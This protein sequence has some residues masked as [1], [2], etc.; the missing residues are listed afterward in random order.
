MARIGAPGTG[1]SSRDPSKAVETPAGL[2]SRRRSSG[3]SRKST[4]QQTVKINGNTVFINGQGFTVA[5]SLQ[6]SFIQGRTG[7]SGS[8]AQTAIAQAQKAQAAIIAK[9]TAAK[10]RKIAEAKIAAAKTFAEKQKIARQYVERKKYDTQ[11]KKILSLK[12]NLIK[13][14]V[15]ENKVSSTDVKT[16]DKL[17]ITQWRDRRG[18]RVQEKVNKST[19]ETT[20]TSFQRP[21]DGGRVRQTGG[22]TIGATPKTATDIA[23]TYQIIP[24]ANPEW[25]FVRMPNGS[26]IRVSTTKKSIV[27]AGVAGHKLLFDKGVIIAVDGKTTFARDE[28]V[29]PEPSV[30]KFER[31]R[32][33]TTTETIRIDS[34]LRSIDNTRNKLRTQKERGKIKKIDDIKLFGYG[35]LSALISIGGGLIGLPETA[36]RIMKDPSMLKQIPSAI[37]KSGKEFGVMLRTSPTEAFGVIAG[38]VVGMVGTTAAINQVSKLSSSV[39]TKLNPR[40][41]GKAVLGKNLNIKTGGGKS[42]NLEV[43]GKI[44]KEKLLSQVNKQGQKL[45]AISSQADDLINFFNKQRTIRKPIPGEATFNSAT[46]TLLKK[47]DS[48]T[49]TKMELFD[50]DLLVRSQGAKGLLE[51]AFFADPT[52]K[53]RPSRLGVVDSNKAG[54]MDYLSGDITFR[55]ARPQILLFEDIKVA[56][57]P[58]YLK[59]VASKIKTGKTLTRAEANALLEWQ[60]KQSGKFK[61]VGFISGES[62]ITLAPR[63]ILKKVKTVGYTSI[64]G[65]RVPII[66][67]SVLK[68]SKIMKSLIKKLDDGIITVAER[69]KLSRMLKTQTGFNYGLSSNRVVSAKYVPIRRI[70]FSS[71]SKISSKL[72]SGKIYK[73]LSSKPSLVSRSG[74]SLRTYKPSKSKIPK[75]PSR[76][77]PP[78][79]PRRSPPKSPKKSPPKSPPRKSP[80][81]SPRPPKRPPVKPPITPPIRTPKGF[82]RKTLSKKTPVYYVVIRRK[83]KLVKLNARPLTLRDARD[84]LAYRLDRGLGRSA[85][86]EPIGKTNRVV[87]LPRNI[88]GYYS[89]VSHKM[90][91]YKIR[92]GEKKAI[93]NGYIEKKKYVGDTKSEIRD[94]QLSRRKAALRRRVVKNRAKTSRRKRP[95]KRKVIKRRIVRRT[96]NKRLIKNKKL[97]KKSQKK[98]KTKKVVKRPVRKKKSLKRKVSRKLSRKPSQKKKRKTIKK[99]KR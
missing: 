76:K 56:R 50:L 95:V 54:L 90:R 10:A 70:G 93:R 91:P 13:S 2:I 28:Y 61:P 94:L 62:E 7:G 89:K 40:Y 55:K 16:G 72:K 43:V 5:P 64:K 65:R 78:K 92:L 22:V 30:E 68:Q 57:F 38:N 77:Y 58:S 73:R 83:G 97:I 39:F 18:N 79:S 21:K 36:Y 42:V 81:G 31:A 3:G 32:G 35:F 87:G 60:L 17:I 82:K 67:V 51:R 26:H 20:Y 75:K 41:T 85:W 19:G 37:S 14:G 44:P 23:N 29:K 99:R 47:L 27:G 48:G 12:S 52:G 49:I 1:F 66:K 6:A 74:K 34:L 11:Y 9:A 46:K 98:K 4:T 96:K 24:T 33:L 15:E 88:K 71:L 59:R 63:E 25:V 53:I 80:P 84:Y 86:F 45:N 8:S 69:A